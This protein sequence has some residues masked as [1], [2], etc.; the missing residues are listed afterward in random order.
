MGRSCVCRDGYSEDSSDYQCRYDYDYS[1]DEIG[2]GFL[3]ILF[4]LP[5]G[6]IVLTIW[7]CLRRRRRA[8]AHCVVEQPCF[9]GGV[10]TISP[11]AQYAY[12][13]QPGYQKNY[14]Y[15]QFQSQPPYSARPN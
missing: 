2:L 1:G 6:I 3:W 7:C 15:N 4:I 14:Q 11:P 10:T 5:V 8:R 9:S 13:T 12:P